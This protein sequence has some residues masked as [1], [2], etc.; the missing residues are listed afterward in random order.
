MT[1]L[2]G[3]LDVLG[4]KIAATNNDQILQASRNKELSIMEEAQV[5]GPQIRSFFRRQSRLKVAAGLYRT[6]PIT[7][8]DTWTG[9]PNFPD[10]RC[11]ASALAARRQAIGA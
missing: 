9:N 5:T 8:S 3:V 10:A 1:I 2:D 4:I 7:T 11:H 6:V